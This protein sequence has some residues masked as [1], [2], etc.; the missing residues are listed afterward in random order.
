MQSVEQ[1][2]FWH[3][4]T[5]PA[6]GSWTLS[7]AQDEEYWKGLPFPQA[8]SLKVGLAKLCSV[9]T[10]LVKHNSDMCMMECTDS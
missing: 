8:G 6:W 5:R 7:A 3:S 9:V 1:S 10:L 2:E 4:N